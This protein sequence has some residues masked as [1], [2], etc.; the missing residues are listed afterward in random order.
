MTITVLATTEIHKE[1][2]EP[3]FW[4]FVKDWRLTL[5]DVREESPFWV[6]LHAQPQSAWWGLNPLSPVYKT[7][8]YT[9]YA[10][11]GHINNLFILS[12][13]VRMVGLEPTISCL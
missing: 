4:G 9:S 11:R 8:A 7:G 6:S 1:K 13:S 5:I 3:L 12:Y 10:S 2:N